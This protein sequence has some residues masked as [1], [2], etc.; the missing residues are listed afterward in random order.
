ML[1]GDISGLQNGVLFFRSI[2][3]DRFIK[4]LISAR[5][6]MKI[7][8][9]WLDVE[10]KGYGR[11][12]MSTDWKAF[13]ECT[14]CRKIIRVNGMLG[15]L[16]ICIDRVPPE[17]RSKGSKEVIRWYEDPT[18]DNLKLANAETLRQFQDLQDRKES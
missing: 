12:W 2:F 8:G 1:K 6:V 14:S 7:K 11:V 16:H 5:E 17:V 9:A 18:E 15:G 10:I 4:S 3:Y 13:S